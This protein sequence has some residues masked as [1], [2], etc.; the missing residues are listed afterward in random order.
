MAVW[1]FWQQLE[2]APRHGVPGEMVRYETKWWYQQHPLSGA[3]WT[4]CNVI[5]Y[6]QVSASHRNCFCPVRWGRSGRTSF[7][8]VWHV[9]RISISD[10]I[11]V[12]Q[13]CSIFSSF[14]SSNKQLIAGYGWQWSFLLNWR[15]KK[16]IFNCVK[17][18]FWLH[19][20]CKISNKVD[21]REHDHSFSFL[22]CIGAVYF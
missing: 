1:R 19:Q 6:T 3:Q 18:V 11:S 14:C 15:S 5:Q 7:L 12:G 10:M 16:S 21:I 2:K 20:T 8:F 4:N 22:T 17:T 13:W 9:A